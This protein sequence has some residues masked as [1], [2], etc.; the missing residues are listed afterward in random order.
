MKTAIE[1]PTN[2]AQMELWAWAKKKLYCWEMHNGLTIKALQAVADGT[3][4]G[5]AI[6]ARQF[7]GPYLEWSLGKGLQMTRGEA[8]GR[9]THIENSQCFHACQRPFHYSQRNCHGYCILSS[10]VRRE[11][12]FLE[13]G[14]GNLWEVNTQAVLS[15]HWIR[16]LRSSTKGFSNFFLKN[17]FLSTLP[18]VPSC[19][20]STYTSRWNTKSRAVVQRFVIPFY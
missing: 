17:M 18:C 14:G 19:S 5:L 16:F 10:R 1:A 4:R 11:C 12:I 20:A 7:L 9:L 15:N 8:I 13:R 2:R 6:T 3:M